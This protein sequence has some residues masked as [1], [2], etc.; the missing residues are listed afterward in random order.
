MKQSLFWII[1]A[2]CGGSTVFA[3]TTV[4]QALQ[5]NWAAQSYTL[6]IAEGKTV[7]TLRFDGASYNAMHHHLPIFTT[8]AAL[9][10][11][12]RVSAVLAEAQYE[13]IALPDG[14]LL[15]NNAPLGNNIVP[16]VQ[17]AT[18]KKR[19]FALLSIVPIRAAVGGGYER[20]VRAN[21]VYTVQAQ[22][23]SRGTRQY[24]TESVFNKGDL[25][26]FKV[27]QDGVYRLD[28]AFVQQLG[29]NQTVPIN[30]IRIYGNGG[31]MLPELSSGEKYDDLVENPIQVVDNNQ[32][33]L[34]DGSDYL[35]FY[36]QSPHQWSFNTVTRRFDWLYNA[37]TD[38]NYYYFNA[39]IG[40]GKR[41]AQ[42][43]PNTATPTVQVNTYNGYAAHE[44]NDENPNKS[45]RTWYGEVFNAQRT[46]QT[47]DF[48]LPNIDTNSP[49]H[50][51]SSLAGRSIGSSSSF[52]TFVNGAT[53]ALQTLGID[54]TSE[55]YETNY[56]NDATVGTV[57][58]STNSDKVSVRVQFN[59]GAAGAEG[60]L[61]YLVL[62]LRRYLVLSANQMPFCDAASVAPNAVAQYNLSANS[63]YTIWDVS[64]IDQVQQ[65]PLNS[66]A[67]G[68]SFVAD[69]SQLHR[70]IAFTNTN[71]LTPQAEQLLVTRQNLHNPADQPNMVI[72]TH[73]D[74]VASA[75]R[76][77]NHHRQHDNL[78]VKVVT[79]QQLYNE[80]ASGAPDITALRDYFKM[81]Y[82]RAASDEQAP[83]YTLLWGD[84]SYD[85]KDTKFKNGTNTNFVPTFESP[86]TLVTVTTYCTDDYYGYLDDNEGF[87]ISANKYLLDIALGRIPI[88]SNEEGET[89]VDKIKRYTQAAS[90]GSWRNDLCFVGD[91]EDGNTHMYD[92]EAVADEVANNYP[93]YNINKIYL[94]AYQQISTSGGSRYPAAKEALNAQ[95]FAGALMFNYS[96]HGGE[97]GWTYERILDPTDMTNWRNSDRLPLL[98]TATCSF[99]RYDNPDK[100]S[101][102]EKL[103]LYDQGGA[104]ALMT[105]VRLVY[106]SSNAALNGAF[107]GRVFER[108]PD[109]TMPTMGEVARQAKNDMQSGVINNYKF[110]LMGD[111]ALRLA[112]PSR[113]AV[114]TTHINGKA[115]AG[116]TAD[117]ISALQ[118]VT[119][120]GE[121]QDLQGNKLTSFN[122]VVFPTVFDKK[123][124]I[125]TLGNDV[126]SPKTDFELRQNVLFKG[127]ASV[128]NGSFEFSFMVPRDINYT[129]GTGRISY[130]ATDQLSDYNGY[131]ESLFV[132]GISNNAVND[133][134][135]PK[136]NIFMGDEQFVFGSVT[137]ANPLLIAKISDQN[138]INTAGSGI[139]HDIV[140]TLN[141]DAANTYTLNRYYKT[142]LNSYQN[143]ELRYPLSKLPEGLHQIEVKAWDTNN[144]SGKGYTE[145]V[146]ASSADL[147]LKNVLN[148][149]NPF[150]NY[151]EFWFEHN[152]PAQLL[153]AMVQVYSMSGRLVKT[154]S[155]QIQAT[156][157]RSNELTWDGLD[158]YGN[159]IGKGVYVYVLTVK[160]AD[161][162]TARQVQRLVVLR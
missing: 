113:T 26:R 124:T 47:I 50:L 52:N 162:K 115:L 116:A 8:R 7:Q 46:E 55:G 127:Q 160:T 95:A 137:D 122:G 128:T 44:N 21:I 32:N 88:K 93:V 53:Q 45:G 34:F 39:D 75:E 17:L 43:A 148:Y 40:A 20:L 68:Y 121:V 141:N 87:N 79:T 130:Y 90:Q 56:G 99:T 81:L 135:P 125:E 84:A 59:V 108:L 37:Y 119:V 18:E 152:Q 63:S 13:A 65:I 1:I 123:V 120:S 94:D 16:M 136:I 100:Y 149:P 145:F 96:G 150:S 60:W 61:D 133:N 105:T 102:G 114:T 147:A 54:K 129:Y 144:N 139:G 4:T 126:G 57:F 35:L 134:E 110:M 76:M 14:L 3:Q 91:D 25:Y 72:V 151:T 38:A 74:F 9:P 70:Y 62:N 86:E 82:D 103:M 69:A 66:T 159:A 48:D 109:G 154:I 67:N 41:I 80:F 49:I 2:L 24:A 58:S 10:F 42:A 117:T 157:Y 106:A 64:R 5:L 112:Y 71:Y 19:P 78:S 77:A 51:L 107:M 92:A 98:V 11:G 28:V 155:Q 138:G 27:A 23:T 22:A 153:T 73:P 118:K 31:G 36:A 131:T 30:Q 12:G 158:D 111:P 161:N 89:V 33:N 29:L 132:G 83:K 85:Y 146:V 104:I 15:P 142:D 97:D 101:I 156:G 6:P 140:G 143:G